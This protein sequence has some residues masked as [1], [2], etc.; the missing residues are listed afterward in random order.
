MVYC[1]PKKELD[2]V[3]PHGSTGAICTT[4]YDGKEMCVDFET[5]PMAKKANLNKAELV[6]L[7]LYTGYTANTRCASVLEVICVS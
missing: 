2:K 5:H 3:L 6:M 4:T 7:R 1:S